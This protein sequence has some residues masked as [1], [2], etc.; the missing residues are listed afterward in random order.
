MPARGFVRKNITRCARILF[1]N[2]RGSTHPGRRTFGASCVDEMPA[3][4]HRRENSAQ[5]ILRGPAS[6]KREMYAG[7]I[8][9]LTP[10]PIVGDALL[11][12]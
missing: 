8:R 5:S 1:L 7:I 12:S 6:F 10:P 2:G 4:R 3:G 9:Q 11:S